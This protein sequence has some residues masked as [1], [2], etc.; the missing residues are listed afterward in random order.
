[1]EAFGESWTSIVSINTFNELCYDGGCAIQL[2]SVPNRLFSCL[3]L[4]YFKASNFKIVQSKRS[5][6]GFRVNGERDIRGE[7]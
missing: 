3:L 6:V 5:E 1:M 7:K 4:V 2:F